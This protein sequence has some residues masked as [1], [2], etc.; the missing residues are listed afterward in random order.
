MSRLLAPLLIAPVIC[1]GGILY[2]YTIDFDPTAVSAATSVS[3]LSNG[4]LTSSASLYRS[5]DGP[6]TGW[7]N[8]CAAVV[9]PSSFAAAFDL[10]GQLNWL[11]QATTNSI[12]GP[13]TY[14]F[15]GSQL[16]PGPTPSSAATSFSYDSP[17]FLGNSAPIDPTVVHLVSAPGPKN[18]IR[19]SAF[20][21]PATILGIVKK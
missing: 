15:T 21:R 12:G 3:Y 19:K 14:S 10:G 16:N 20:S 18:R 6:L 13:G 17:F 2:L 8:F 9:G 11:F 1:S 4:L 7:R 5:G